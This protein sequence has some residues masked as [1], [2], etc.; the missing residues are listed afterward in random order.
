MSDERSPDQVIAERVR[1]DLA[2]IRAAAELGWRPGATPDPGANA[3]PSLDDHR[4]AIGLPRLP[5]KSAPRRPILPRPITVPLAVALADLVNRGSF[6][7]SWLPL[8]TAGADA[9]ARSERAIARAAAAG[10]ITRGNYEPSRE[11][12]FFGIG[13]FQGDRL[14]RLAEDHR[15]P[16]AY[17][18]ITATTKWLEPADVEVVLG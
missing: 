17:H 3:P 10:L 6:H 15:S 4:R 9:V 11:Q 7:G 12:R 18:W 14:P 8:R 5:A 2:T 16:L 13:G 1:R